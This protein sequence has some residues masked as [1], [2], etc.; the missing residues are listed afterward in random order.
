MIMS[1]MDRLT[2]GVGIR[3][4]GELILLACQW[5]PKEEDWSDSAS[6]VD[7]VWIEGELFLPD[8]VGNGFFVVYGT[9]K[10]HSI[11]LVEHCRQFETRA[12]HAVVVDDTAQLVSKRRIIEQ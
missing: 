9:M 3:S 4:C 10:C 5:S 8:E 6:L 12:A 11:L 1:I 7:I 2:H